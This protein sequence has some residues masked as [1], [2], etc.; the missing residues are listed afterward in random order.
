[1]KKVLFFLLVALWIFGFKA[2]ATLANSYEQISFKNKN[3]FFTSLRDILSESFNNDEVEKGLKAFKFQEEIRNYKDMGALIAAQPT[4]AETIIAHVKV[5]NL[6]NRPTELKKLKSEIFEIA[7]NSASSSF[8]MDSRMIA[9]VAVVPALA[10]FSNSSSGPSLSINDV[11][12]SDEAAG[13]VT[14]TVTLS[15]ASENTVT[16]KYATSN[17]TATA[18]SD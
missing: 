17:G 18:G 8:S 5:L 9:A 7:K 14:F 12:T 10:I 6:I 1:M 3:E 2:P 13:S 16:V 15:E 4:T 11:V